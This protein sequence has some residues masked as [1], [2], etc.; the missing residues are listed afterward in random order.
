MPT[1]L[2]TLLMAFGLMFTFTAC[3]TETAGEEVME[4]TMDDEIA[5]INPD[6][7]T[8]DGPAPTVRGTIDAL[9]GGLTTLP[10]A[11]ALQNI[12]GWIAELEPM[13]FEG[14]EEI[15]DNLEELASELR[16]NE[17]SDL[18][19]DDIA[20]RLERL[21]ELTTAAAVGAAGTAGD[22]LRELGSMLSSAGAGLR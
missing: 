18:D 3:E 8:Y 10:A 11:T 14:S 5:P 20:E 21:G 17:V 12:E 16:E 13:D 2:L 15:T 22:E 4:E 1:R 7:S 9:S 19:G 6:I